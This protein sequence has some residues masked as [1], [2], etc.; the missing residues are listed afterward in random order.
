MKRLT[1]MLAL[2]ATSSL[3]PAQYLKNNYIDWGPS[4][5]AFLSTINTWTSSYKINDDDAFFV[6]RVKPKA[7]FRNTATQVKN[8]LTA[9]NDKR[10]LCWLPWE[11]SNMRG[12]NM[13]A[14]PCGMFDTEI[15]SMWSYVDHWGDWNAPLGRVPAALSDVAHKNGVAVSGVAGIPNTSIS[16]TD[17][18]SWYTNISEAYGAKAAPMLFYYGNDGLGYNS[19]YS[20]GTTNGQ[21]RVINFHKRLVKDLRALGNP[22]AENIWYDGVND[23]G[24]YGFDSALNGY[25]NTYGTDSEPVFSVFAN[26][27]S[28]TQTKQQTAVNNA[29]SFGRSS[30]YYYSGLNMQGGNPSMNWGAIK[31]YATSIG[32]WGAHTSNMFFQYR[33]VLGAAPATKQRSYL[34]STERWFGGGQRNPV[35]H[36][37]ATSNVSYHPERTTSPGMCSM[38]SARS[39]LQ[40]NL[41]EEPFVTFFNLGNGTFLNY[42]GARANDNEWGNV[43]VQDYLPTW[44]YWFHTDWLGRTTS[45]AT[46]GLDAQFVWDDAYVGGSC[47]EISGTTSGAYLHLFK[48]QFALQAGDIITLRYKLAGGSANADLA[49]SALGSE[50]TVITGSEFN[51]IAAEQHHDS[52]VWM[53]KTFTVG[54]GNTL[55]GKTIAA[56]ALH[57][58]SADNAKVYLGELSIARGTYATPAAPTSLSFTTLYNGSTG[59]DLKLYWDMPGKNALPTPTF[60][61]DV[62]TSLFRVW[63]QVDDQ[64]PVLMGLTTSWAALMYRTPNVGTKVRYGVSALSLD[65]ASESAVTWTDWQTIGSMSYEYDDAIQIDKTTVKPGE[66]FTVSYVDPN[67]ES[68]TWTIT[69][70]SGTTM[71]TGTGTS[72]TA[73]LSATGIYNVIVTGTTH[74][75][76]STQTNQTRTYAAYVA[77]S[78]ES[79]GALPQIKTF[80][81]NGKT[82]NIEINVN[83]DVN[84]AFTAR[85]SDGQTSR[86]IYLDSKFFGAKLTDFGIKGGTSTSAP[87][88]SSN[89]SSFSV[90]YWIKLNKLVDRQGYLK[91]VNPTSSTWPRNNW[92][93][94]YADVYN[95]ETFPPYFYFTWQAGTQT[96]YQSNGSSK[97]GANIFLKYTGANQPQLLEGQWTHICV[98]FD[99]AT[100]SCY[101]YG[102]TSTRTTRQNKWSLKPKLYVNGVRL[103]PDIVSIGGVD[104][105]RNFKSSASND[106]YDRYDGLCAPET[107][108]YLFVGGPDRIGPIDGIMDHFAVWNKALTASEVVAAMGDFSS[109]P[110]GLVGLYTFDND[111]NADNTY[112]PA[113]GSGPKVGLYGATYPNGSESAAVF[114]VLEPTLSTGF[115]ILNGATD[116]KTTAT[117]HVAGA[118][119]KSSTI[120][121]TSAAAA[122]GRSIKAAGEDISGTAV[123][124]WPMESVR[125]ITLTLENAYGSDSKTITAVQVTDPM[126]GIGDVWADQDKLQV[127]Q[128]QDDIFVRVPADGEFEFTI[129]S[130]DGRVKAHRYARLKAQQ[131]VNLHLPD[132]GVYVLGVKKDGKPYTGYKFVRQ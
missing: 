128:A 36:T 81:A 103:Y 126:T 73:S 56:I 108:E 90:S 124:T 63:A 2:F 122:T 101:T 42:K 54:E 104:Q 29:T 21:T 13:N 4:S 51:V 98:T 114:D 74:T 107:S 71:K 129:Y 91:I 14:I 61:T 120:N 66:E 97:S 125:D 41:T 10:L 77:V 92:G 106:T 49:F 102:G 38:M 17:Y 9:S 5:T 58:N 111:I 127:I 105:T 57:F 89:T 82:E 132:Q 12:F 25:Q 130:G 65:F 113:M 72:I 67:H 43:G 39:T 22:N 115:P 123:V 68:A 99:W 3:L 79:T 32:L 28:M 26:Y 75:G 84:L 16:S 85:N 33:Y 53:E 24:T 52:D 60:N 76:G 7:R 59:T 11:D 30:L 27:N 83:E 1:L 86:G 46:T 23:S 31:N 35:L 80:T 93:T 45:G 118:D 121:N 20:G 40:W 19:E 18:S 44:R 112:S 15:F 87:A 117:W 116:V 50:S 109:V 48:T 131:S 8:T 70:Q 47:L 94:V 110:D 78:P 119:I 55:A 95:T 62:H 6:S 69:N 34:L 64:E 88:T 100:A 96:T 37:T